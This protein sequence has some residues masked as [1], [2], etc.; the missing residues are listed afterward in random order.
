VTVTLSRSGVGD[1]PNPVAANASGIWTYSY[2]GTMLSEGRYAFTARATDGNLVKSDY[3]APEFLVTVDRT[4]PTVA[5]S[6]PSSTTSLGPE[7]LVTARDTFGIP[8]GATVTLDVD[9][10]NDGN[11]TDAGETG[12]ATGN[13]TDGQVTI[14]LPALS[15]TGTYQVRAR[16]TDL[17]GNEGTSATSSF[18]VTTVSNP[19]TVSNPACRAA[20]T[21]K[22][23]SVSV[24]CGV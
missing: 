19:W 9:K 16:V 24:S 20:P 6:V 11:F 3:S 12:Y 1:L 8:S 22:T 23:S 14:K 7:V 5:L 10:N 4:A 15:T 2:T 18:T 13:L 17:A 21:T